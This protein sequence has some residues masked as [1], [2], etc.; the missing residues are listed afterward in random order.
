MSEVEISN[1]SKTFKQKKTTFH[2]LKNVSFDIK[3]GEIFGLLGPNGAGKTTLINILSGILLPTS[4]KVKIHGFDMLKERE[5]ILKFINVGSHETEFHW[6]LN[7]KE[8]LYFFGKFYGLDSKQIKIKTKELSELLE[9]EDLKKQFRYLSTGQE[10]RVILA[11][12]LIN[13]PKFLMLDEPTVGLDPDIAKRT[14]ELV[15]EISKNFKTTILLTSHYMTEVE[16]LCDRIAFLYKGEIVDIGKIGKVKSSLFS[17]FEL[18]VVVKKIKHASLL[19]KLGFKIKGNTLLIELSEEDS[20]TPLISQL[21]KN[22]F[23]I[24][25]IRVQKPTLEDYFLEMMKK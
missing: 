23:E 13:D 5:K 12:S 25:D 8:I 10:Y 18:F 1:V 3:Q 6:S 2:A 22:N 20:V 15:Y 4:G 19:K 24:L 7:A 11:K 16:Q 17:T 14:S 21:V 9:I